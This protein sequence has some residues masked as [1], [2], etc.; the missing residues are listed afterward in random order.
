MKS[1]ARSEDT[2]M[3]VP[4][5]EKP[6]AFRKRSMALRTLS[7]PA[8]SLGSTST[9][10]PSDMSA[11]GGIL[12]LSTSGKSWSR[13][14]LTVPLQTRRFELMM[15]RC[16]TGSTVVVAGLFMVVSLGV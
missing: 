11:L 10:R 4:A 15:T 14:T 12:S 3:P 6:S 9:L 5:N 13:S 8:S 2:A 7:M 16:S 1:L